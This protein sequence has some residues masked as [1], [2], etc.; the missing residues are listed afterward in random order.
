MWIYSSYD[1]YVPPMSTQDSEPSSP[2]DN[3]WHV[4]TL[5]AWPYKDLTIILMYHQVIWEC[6]GRLPLSTTKF[7]V[8]KHQRLA[9][10]G[11]KIPQPRAICLD[12]QQT[13]HCKYEKPSEERSQS[14]SFSSCKTK[15]DFSFRESMA[16]HYTT[17]TS[18]YIS[19]AKVFPYNLV[20]NWKPWNLRQVLKHLV[21]WSL[22]HQWQ[23]KW[24][25]EMVP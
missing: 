12:G 25:T 10:T 18:P 22:K 9:R 11:A 8:C 15:R 5:L 21:I 19:K 20:I 17:M 7:A 13:V 14:N 23:S 6:S 4:V 24:N 3:H 1:N 16:T 2:L